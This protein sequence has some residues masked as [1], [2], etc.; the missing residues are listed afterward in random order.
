[1]MQ[2]RLGWCRIPLADCRRLRTSGQAQV[3]TPT[4]VDAASDHPAPPNN[5]LFGSLLITFQFAHGAQAKSTWFV[6]A[7]RATRETTHVR[8]S[9]SSTSLSHTL[10]NGLRGIEVQALGPPAHSRKGLTL[11]DSYAPASAAGPTQGS[12][13]QLQTKQHIATSQSLQILTGTARCVA[14]RFEQ[15]HLSRGSRRHRWGLTAHR[16]SHTAPAPSSPPL[17]A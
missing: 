11:T 3:H 12:Q 14:F 5:T 4:G 9:D 8:A 10:Q 7:S 1:M 15:A 13:R 17:A 6:G 2:G 16:P